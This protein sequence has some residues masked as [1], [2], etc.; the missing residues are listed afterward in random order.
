MASIRSR[1]ECVFM[2]MAGEL[3]PK[4]PTATL[5]ELNFP[6]DRTN[7]W[8]T[9]WALTGVVA[10]Q[11][12]FWATNLRFS[13]RLRPVAATSRVSA[14]PAPAKLCIKRYARRALLQELIL[15]KCFVRAL[16]PPEPGARKSRAPC[17]RWLPRLLP[18]K[19]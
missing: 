16:A 3:V 17:A 12:A 9:I 6:C 13:P 5:R 7:A 4:F 14:R 10:R 2:D 11:R 15:S 1:R 19:L 18:G 8:P